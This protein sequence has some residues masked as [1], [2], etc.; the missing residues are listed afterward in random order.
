M[1]KAFSLLLMLFLLGGCAKIT[2]SVVD[3]N[4]DEYYYEDEEDTS[5]DGE[6]VA[7][8][9]MVTAEPVSGEGSYNFTVYGVDFVCMLGDLYTVYDS[10]PDSFEAYDGTGNRL[11]VALSPD[12]DETADSYS[13]S[14]LDMFD[15]AAGSTDVDYV[16]SE[17]EIGGLSYRYI[18]GDMGG[19]Y[20]GYAFREEC[21]RL[22]AIQVVA[23][24]EEAYNE[25][26]Y[27]FVN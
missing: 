5:E 16:E 22:L 21:N 25:L 4:S 6:N 8:E 24:N 3:D 12:E 27:S 17:L 2:D 1:K 20:Y 13:E 23:L 15:V 18:S 19:A 26:I 10:S 7:A 9:P 14:V 11:H